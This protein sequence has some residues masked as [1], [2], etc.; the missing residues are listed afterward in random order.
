MIDL[1]DPDEVLLQLGVPEVLLPLCTIGARGVP[2]VRLISNADASEADLV[3]LA[4]LGLD[5]VIAPGTEF[6][7]RLIGSA[8]G[9]FTNIRLSRF[10]SEGRYVGVAALEGASE[11]VTFQQLVD[12]E[13][14][15]DV[16][17]SAL[18]RLAYAECRSAFLDAVVGNANLRRLRVDVPVLRSG[19]SIES[20]L[21]G[22]SIH[23]GARLSDVSYLKHP[24]SL[25]Q[26]KVEGA[27]SF[28]L[29]TLL[30]APHL[31]RLEMVGCRELLNIESL[32]ELP[33]LDSVTI[34]GARAAR[35]VNSLLTLSARELNVY[36]NRLFGA[37]F[38]AAA[39][40]HVGWRLEKYRPSPTAMVTKQTKARFID[41]VDA[42]SF[43]PFQ[44]LDSIDGAYS[45]KYDDWDTL[46]ELLNLNPS[47]VDS[48]V[49]DRVVRDV[50]EADLPRLLTEGGVS[51][52]P[53]RDATY[54]TVPNR[55]DLE[56]IARVLSRAWASRARMHALGEQSGRG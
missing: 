10:S 20:P 21:Q 41:G 34:D 47:E 9:A 17:L 52:D 8:M 50:L 27:Q 55:E 29:S 36:D 23:A 42:E 28:D 39:A 30:A 5:L 11:L 38:R 37:E 6:D 24:D 18:P 56:A 32:L 12:I 26:L 19:F 4:R 49:G 53:E 1:R 44:L 15:E 13:V 25:L 33:A 46:A 2:M 35:N 3:G 31:V 48:E 40:K 51:F 14:D 16:D 22:L 7:L 45:L 43:A 54:L